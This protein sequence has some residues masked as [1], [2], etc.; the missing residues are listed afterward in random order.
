[1]ARRPRHLSAEDR[2]LWKKVTDSTERMHAATRPLTEL[3]T[4]KPAP[5]S[6]KPHPKSRPPAFQIGQRAQ[7]NA[8]PHDLAPSL[9]NSVASQPVSMDRKIFGKM[10]KGRLSPEARIDLHGM[11]IAQAHPVLVRFI[12][13]AAAADRRLVLVITGK[14]KHRDDG[15][16]I[17]VRHGVLRHQVPHWLNTM[18]LKQYVLQISEAHLKHGG[19]GAY[20]V[21]LRRR[22]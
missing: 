16:P 8:Q 3:P 1:M 21:Y 2:A 11:T 12:L 5:A 4:T 7:P 10:K 20:Y 9:S 22:R 19:Q 6:R 17:P 18:P 14:G 15:G 13:D